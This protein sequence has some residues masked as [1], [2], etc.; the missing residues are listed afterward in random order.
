MRKKSS[1]IDFFEPES[2]ELS[3]TNDDTD[4]EAVNGKTRPFLKWAN[5]A[6]G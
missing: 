3:D 4:L 6:F 2:I 1:V 5:Q